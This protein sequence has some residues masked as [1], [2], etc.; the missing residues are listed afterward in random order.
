VLDRTDSGVFDENVARLLDAGVPDKLASWVA[1]MRWLPATFDVVAVATQIDAERRL[2]M[3]TY[4]ELAS[5]LELSWLRDRI[6]E[7]PRTNRW[8]SLTRAALRDDLASIQRRL[9]AQ[10]LD[11][12]D[13]RSGAS[14][15]IDAWWASREEAIER[16]LAT[17]SD[18]KA[19]RTY[20]AT[21]LPVALRELRGLVS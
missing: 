12:A 15:A 8:E 20:D 7:L 13:A 2:V 11:S 4:F 10:L 5:R 9:T 21:T 1:A 6:Y 19:S 14:A 3:Q 16:W 17:L 18:V